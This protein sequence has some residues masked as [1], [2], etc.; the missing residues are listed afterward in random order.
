[1]KN[2][3]PICL[4]FFKGSVASAMTLTVTDRSVILE[5]GGGEEGIMSFV[6]LLLQ[7]LFGSN[8]FNKRNKEGLDCARKGQGR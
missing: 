6:F 8:L 3:D 7:P 2:M 4:V 5:R 1:M